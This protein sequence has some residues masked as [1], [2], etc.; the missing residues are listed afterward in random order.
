[1]IKIAYPFI[2]YNLS[3]HQNKVN[4][5]NI[6][7]PGVDSYDEYNLFK[8]VKQSKLKYIDLSGVEKVYYKLIMNGRIKNFKELFTYCNHRSTPPF[9]GGRK[10]AL[11]HA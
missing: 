5:V 4:F 6:I 1:M 7:L 2:L 3:L 9:W 10:H 11:N 8:S